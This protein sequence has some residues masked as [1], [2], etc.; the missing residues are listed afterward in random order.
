MEERVK[1]KSGGPFHKLKSSFKE[2]FGKSELPTFKTVPPDEKPAGNYQE[3][4][5]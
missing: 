5:R 1:E 3:I 4:V 2:I